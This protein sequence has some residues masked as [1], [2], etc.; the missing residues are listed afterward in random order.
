MADK[1]DRMDG[2][3]LESDH[4]AQ[5]V[6]EGLM[7]VA[8]PEAVFSKP[9]KVGDALVIT[10]SEV[11]VGLGFGFG[12]GR[13]PRILTNLPDESRKEG[14]ESALGSGSG[15]GGGAGARPVAVITIREDMVSVEPI[16]DRTKIALAFFTMLGSIFFM[17]AQMRRRK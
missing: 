10:A 7:A 17:G 2:A 8:T 6:L 5:E 1:V 15:G 13:G 16:M 12:S 3:A 11:N 4:R 14:T 9:V